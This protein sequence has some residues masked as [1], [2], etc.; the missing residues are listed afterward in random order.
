MTR[1]TDR[2]RAFSGPFGAGA[3]CANSEGDVCKYS[4]TY[5]LLDFVIWYIWS[6][7]NKED[8]FGED[9]LS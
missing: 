6:G 8:I 1:Q 7:R 4:T 3:N 2:Q 5:I 9:G